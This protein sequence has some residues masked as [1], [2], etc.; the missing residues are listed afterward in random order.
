MSQMGKLRPQQGRGHDQV[1]E[2]QWDCSLDQTR[3]EAPGG[4]RLLEP[5]GPCP[6]A[7]RILH[8]GNSAE[9]GSDS[10][11]GQDERLS[12]APL[13]PNPQASTMEYK[14]NGM[15]QH[16]QSREWNHQ[17]QI[18]RVGTKDWIKVGF[19][20]MLPLPRAA[21][22]LERLALGRSVGKDHPNEH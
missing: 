17:L 20:N 19:P 18:Q 1:G 3:Q 9:K 4:V 16:C 13:P 2:G 7:T 11:E 6:W 21:S 5:G 22:Y 12:L 8:T 15:W 10:P 14:R